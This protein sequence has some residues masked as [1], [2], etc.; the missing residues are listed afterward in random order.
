MKDI[1]LIMEKAQ[2]VKH[3]SLKTIHGQ[4]EQQAKTIKGVKVE[5]IRDLYED[6]KR[7]LNDKCLMLEQLLNYE[8]RQNLVRTK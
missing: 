5:W 1:E 2:K 4:L 8:F 7:N 6:C 3:D